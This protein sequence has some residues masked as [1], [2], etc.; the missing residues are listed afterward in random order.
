MLKKG[1]WRH[2][3]TP[4][5]EVAPTSLIQFRL[6]AEVIAIEGKLARCTESWDYCVHMLKHR[7]I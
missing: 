4:S 6:Q 7:L 3:I 2:F 5:R 1:V